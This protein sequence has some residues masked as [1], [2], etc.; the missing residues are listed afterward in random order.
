[1]LVRVRA[2]DG[3]FRL[4]VEKE[5]TFGDMIQQV[6]LRRITSSPKSQH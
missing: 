4:T 6:L 5:T 3:M 1:M 2:P